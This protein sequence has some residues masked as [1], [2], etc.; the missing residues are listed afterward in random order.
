MSFLK[1]KLKVNS[2]LK[3]VEESELIKE[4][5]EVEDFL[6]L[7]SKN[8]LNNISPELAL[9]L[10]V[11]QFN[12]GLKPIFQ[13][14]VEAIFTGSICLKEAVEK[15][16]SS[17]NNPQSKQLFHYLMDLIGYDAKRRASVVIKTLY[18]LKENQQLYYKRQ[19]ILKSQEFKIKFLVNI[20]SLVLG[21]ICSLSPWFSITPLL[22]NTDY[23]INPF[24]ISFKLHSSPYV[25]ITFLVISV[26]NA[27]LLY[28][29]VKIEHK[30]LFI[31]LAPLLFTAA[32]I[33]GTLI[34]STILQGWV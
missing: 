3:N 24:N 15:I 2:R 32:Y 17:L 11:N 31:L 4:L 23:I 10:A 7:L 34:L 26:L 22:L 16:I 13:N 6:I 21:M 14:A 27:Y 1:I 18:R 20:M 33:T 29:S 19:S 30:L 8:L 28:T 25:I 5:F 9:K 12:G